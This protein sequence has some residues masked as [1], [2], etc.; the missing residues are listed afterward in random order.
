MFV[1]SL[2]G[3]TI[4]EEASGEIEIEDSPTSARTGVYQQLARLFAHP[5]ADTYAAATAGEWP[6]RLAHDAKLLP[7]AFDYGS[8]SI[9]ASVSQADFE[10]EY[11]RLLDVGPGAGGQPPPLVAGGYSGGDRKQKL[12]EVVRFYEYFG[13]HAS[14]E[15]PRP[16]DHLATEFEFMKFLT[17]KEAA[18]AS[19]RLKA[20]FRRAQQDFIEHQLLPWLPE[21]ARRTAEQSPMPFWAWAVKT[22]VT[23]VQA[24][25]AAAAAPVT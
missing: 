21:L 3:L 1:Y 20:S 14:A 15:D 4:D 25:A 6:E 12:E 18:S 8:A 16:P 2:A 10:R 11:T 19:P 22:A 13:L 7:F 5:D 24:D 9:P 17:Y 23:F